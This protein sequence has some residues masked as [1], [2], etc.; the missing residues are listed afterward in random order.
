[1]TPRP[2][3]WQPDASSAAPQASKPPSKFKK[4]T[5]FF[6]KTADGKID[7]DN[8]KQMVRPPSI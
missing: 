4:K 6:L 3:G 5:I 8:I 7:A 1:M 2:R